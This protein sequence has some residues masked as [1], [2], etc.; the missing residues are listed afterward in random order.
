MW[1]YLETVTHSD[2]SNIGEQVELI[3]IPTSGMVRDRIVPD[4]VFEDGVWNGQWTASVEPGL[5]IIR[6]TLEASN[7]VGMASIDADISDGGNVD[8]N[9][10]Y[11]GWLHLSTQWLDFNGTQHHAMKP[12]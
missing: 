10:V 6:A 12:G 11:G 5:W 7:L 4:K 8:I 1:T 9:L 3:L 2:L